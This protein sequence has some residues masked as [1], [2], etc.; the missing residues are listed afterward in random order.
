MTWLKDFNHSMYLGEGIGQ[1]MEDMVRMVTVM[2][3]LAVNFSKFSK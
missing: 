2:M 3:L 1:V